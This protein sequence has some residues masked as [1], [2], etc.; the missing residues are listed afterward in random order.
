MQGG[1]GAWLD[2]KRASDQPVD[3]GQRHALRSQFP[4]LCLAHN[5]VRLAFTGREANSTDRWYSGPW[6]CSQSEG[7]PLGPLLPGSKS[8]HYVLSEPGVE[9]VGTGREGREARLPGHPHNGGDHGQGRGQRGHGP[10]RRSTRGHQEQGKQD[11]CG[12]ASQPPWAEPLPR[13]ARR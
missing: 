4:G 1:V 7:G 8:T 13:Q 2:T 9:V 3:S 10:P 12:S 11:P 5:P 6:P